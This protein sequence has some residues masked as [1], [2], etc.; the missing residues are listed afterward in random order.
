MRSV[1]AAR[2]VA[3]GADRGTRHRAIRATCYEQNLRRYAAMRGLSLGHA[4]KT[5][6]SRPAGV[7]RLSIKPCGVVVTRSYI[8][9]AFSNY[10]TSGEPIALTHALPKRH[11]G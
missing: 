11:R 3:P 8:N 4:S 1:T 2:D 7:G 9:A 10:F 6:D 5:D